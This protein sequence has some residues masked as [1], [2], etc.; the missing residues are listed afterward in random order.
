MASA[1]TCTITCAA[2]AAMGARRI[3]IRANELRHRNRNHCAASPP[4]STSAERTRATAK[5]R[6]EQVAAARNS[7]QRFLA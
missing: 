6:R 3:Q 4:I 1:Q 2:M 5:T 7:F